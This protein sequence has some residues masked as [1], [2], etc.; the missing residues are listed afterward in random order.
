MI[1]DM[2]ITYRRIACIL[3]LSCLITFFLQIEDKNVVCAQEEVKEEQEEKK[4]KI[5][6]EKSTHADSVVIQSS[7]SDSTRQKIRFKKSVL[8]KKNEIEL[9]S[10]KQFIFQGETCSIGD[11][12]INLKKAMGQNLESIAMV[13]KSYQK[14]SAG[15][16]LMVLG[17]FVM[18]AGYLAPLQIAETET[19][20][21]YWFPGVTLGGIIAGVGFSQQGSLTRDLRNSVAVYND[22]LIVDN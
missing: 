20:I 17:G 9:L 8:A 22:S 12:G 7:K 16:T 21:W 13:D 19:T 4:P 2:S 15:K 18:V 3:L 10:S 11:K 5:I 1:L 14:N 6:F